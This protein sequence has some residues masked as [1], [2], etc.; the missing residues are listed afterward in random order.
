MH[1]GFWLENGFVREHMIA[2][3]KVP[4][5]WQLSF[6]ASYEVLAASRRIALFAIFS[7]L[8]ANQSKS[9]W[10]YCHIQSTSLVNHSPL[11]GYIDSSVDQ[12]TP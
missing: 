12:F 8:L 1:T 5:L 10:D 4:S 7:L 3:H 9:W 11:H 6:T 2:L